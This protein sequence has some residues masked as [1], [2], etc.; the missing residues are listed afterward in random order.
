M[1]SASAIYASLF[2]CCLNCVPECFTAYPS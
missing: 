1:P 2:C